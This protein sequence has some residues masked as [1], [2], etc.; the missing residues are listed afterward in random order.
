[1]NK[2]DLEIPIHGMTWVGCVN[3]VQFAIEKISGVLSA[4]V[5]LPTEKAFVTYDASAIQ[6]DNF[7]ESITAAIA[8]A[9]Y[10]VPSFRTIGAADL[11]IETEQQSVADNKRLKLI[12]GIVLTVPLFVL[13]MG[14]GL[15]ELNDSFVSSRRYCHPYC[16][17]ST[18]LTV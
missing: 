1:M 11:D 13:S 10:S 7:V 16:R 15:Q 18:V 9:G 5:S 14:R 17:D 2:T 6:Q 4:S 12:V 3:Q 8:A